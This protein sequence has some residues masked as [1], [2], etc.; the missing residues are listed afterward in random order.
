[1]PSCIFKCSLLQKSQNKSSQIRYYWSVCVC[2]CVCVL[3]QLLLLCFKELSTQKDN[4]LLHTLNPML[5]CLRV[6]NVQLS[7]GPNPVYPCCVDLTQRTTV[8]GETGAPW[9]M[10]HSLPVFVFNKKYYFLQQLQM[11]AI[12]NTT[13][14]CLSPFLLTLKVHFGRI[15]A[16]FQGKK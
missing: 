4:P 15:R 9:V 12:S 11:K 7:C 1:M 10:G 5:K 8:V 13:R 6:T 14:Q 16:L 2:V 3:L